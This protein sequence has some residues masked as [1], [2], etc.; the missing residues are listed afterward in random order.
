M[1]ITPPTKPCFAHACQV[2]IRRN[3]LMCGKHWAM[4]PEDIQTAVYA[5][6]REMQRGGSLRA[7][8]IATIKAQLAVAAR[9]RLGQPVLDAL[10]N[11]IRNLE[12][13]PVAHAQPQTD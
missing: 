7:Y 3:L 10:E 12:K 11:R 2:L 9:E 5:T 4:V 13:G 8:C 1:T 6:Y